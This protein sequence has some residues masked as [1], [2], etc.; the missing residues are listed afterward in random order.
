M[1]EI[2]IGTFSV[3]E[4]DSDKGGLLKLFRV[5]GG[6]SEATHYKWRPPATRAGT[7]RG[8]R[9]GNPGHDAGRL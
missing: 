4:I 9:T 7:T 3:T 2:L 5:I 8:L 1:L 6:P